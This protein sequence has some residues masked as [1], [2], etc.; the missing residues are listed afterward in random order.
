MYSLLRLS[1]TV[2]PISAADWLLFVYWYH[3]GNAQ[4]TFLLYDPW[5]A[6]ANQRF[7]ASGFVAGSLLLFGAIGLRLLLPLLK[8]QPYEIAWRQAMTLNTLIVA[9]AVLLTTQTANFNPPL[10]TG[11]GALV[12]LLGLNAILFAGWQHFTY[13]TSTIIVSL[14]AIAVYA[15]S[16]LVLFI[17]I[18]FIDVIFKFEVAQQSSINLSFLLA[19]GALPLFLVVTTVGLW[20]WYQQQPTWQRPPS[21]PLCLSIILLWTPGFASAHYFF[22]SST[23]YITNIDNLV[24]SAKVGLI[25][26]SV[27]TALLALANVIV[28]RRLEQ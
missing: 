6:D 3:L 17:M 21:I 8:R 25:F 20:V 19:V 12:A 16:A 24:N 10:W 28:T 23:H 9:P 18:Y 27:A 14:L 7:V 1:A 22:A 4:T 15:F 5:V 11:L 13:L 26:G 2:L